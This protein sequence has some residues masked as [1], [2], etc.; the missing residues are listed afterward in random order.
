MSHSL[1]GKVA[2]VTG[3]TQG[4]GLAIATEFAEQGATVVVTGRDQRRLDEAVATIGQQASGVRADAGSPTAMDALLK[5]VK[6]RSGRLDVVVA[7]AVV[8]AHAPLARGGPDRSVDGAEEPARADW[9]RAR[10]RLGRGVPRERRVKLRQWRRTVCRW[11][12][13]AGRVSDSLRMRAVDSDRP[14]L[15]WAGPSVRGRIDSAWVPCR[16]AS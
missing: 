7:N 6:A 5:D 3:G 10:D 15:M 13:D 14:H 8:D 2:V 4:I 11:R 9:R 16:F 12:A 1:D